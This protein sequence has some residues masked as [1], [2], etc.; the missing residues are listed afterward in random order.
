MIQRFEVP[1]CELKIQ[2]L[3]V[4]AD[5][6]GVGSLWDGH[7]ALVEHPG[8]RNLRRTCFVLRGDP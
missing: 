4:L 1:F 3:A 6:L 5:V 7:H 8:E 2:S